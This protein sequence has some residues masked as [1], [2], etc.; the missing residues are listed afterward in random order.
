VHLGSRFE[1][2]I[3][4]IDEI[5]QIKEDEVKEGPNEEGSA[6]FKKC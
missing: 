6:R 1:K 2:I 3:L 5:T 4:P